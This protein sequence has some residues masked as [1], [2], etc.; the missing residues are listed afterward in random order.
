MQKYPGLGARRSMRTIK[1][2][3]DNYSPVIE[4]TEELRENQE[5]K[6]EIKSKKQSTWERK[7]EQKEREKDEKQ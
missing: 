5:R 4:E 1:K 7:R 2:F 6:D 3:Q